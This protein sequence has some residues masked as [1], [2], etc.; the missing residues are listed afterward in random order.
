MCERV[1]RDDVAHVVAI[2]EKTVETSQCHGKQDETQ[3]NRGE[4]TGGAIIDQPITAWQETVETLKR[5]NCAGAAGGQQQY[6]RFQSKRAPNI[7]HLC[8]LLL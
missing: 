2:T 6:K 3:H 7:P 1:G 8:V 4:Q 5:Q